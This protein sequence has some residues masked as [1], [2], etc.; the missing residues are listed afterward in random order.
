MQDSTVEYQLLLGEELLAALTFM[1]PRNWLRRE[2]ALEQG[3]SHA[4]L[5]VLLLNT[6]VQQFHLHKALLSN[7]APSSCSG[8]AT[9]L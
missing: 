7:L 9:D 4:Q 8:E 1:L 5:L 6:L 3:N 2:C